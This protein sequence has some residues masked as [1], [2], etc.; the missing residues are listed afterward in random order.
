MKY[1]GIFITVTSFLLIHSVAMFW[2][3]HNSIFSFKLEASASMSANS[4]D[5]EQFDEL[6]REQLWEEQMINDLNEK[7]V[8]TKDRRKRYETFHV[9]NL[10][11][12]RAIQGK[13]ASSWADFTS[14]YKTRD[15]KKQTIPTTNE[16]LQKEIMPDKIMTPFDDFLVKEELR[17][18]KNNHK[19]EN[20]F[21]QSS[22]ILEKDNMTDEDI[23]SD[24]IEYLA[25]DVVSSEN[26]SNKNSRV[27]QENEIEIPQNYPEPIASSV[28]DSKQINNDPL[29]TNPKETENMSGD[30]SSDKEQT[31]NQLDEEEEASENTKMVLILTESRHGSTWLMDMLSYPDTSVPV[32][33]PLNTPFLKMY[34]RSDEIRKEALDNGH[35]PAIYGD[36]RSVILARICLC[37]FHGDKIEDL[38]LSGRRYGSIAGI[39]Y[40][41]KRFGME[42]KEVFYN[43]LRMCERNDSM[44]VPK[45]IRLYNISELSILPQLGCPNFKV[46]HLVRDPRAVFLSR[47]RVFHE[48]YDGNILLG[49]RFKGQE[50]FSEE[51]MRR[52]ARDLCSHHVH[53]YQVGINPPDWLKDRYKMVIYEDMATEPD[54]WARDLLNFIGT[55]YTDI[56]K[57]YVY[58]TTHIK[59]RGEKEKG[60]YSVERESKEIVN[61]WKK[62][63]IPSHWKTIEEEC[64]DLLE[65][66]GYELEFA[67]HGL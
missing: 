42:Y 32:F 45:T 2:L 21:K 59:E 22:S 34:A 18:T 61:F 4:H 43:S 26:Y 5:K 65:I 49:D 36:W 37:D 48:L 29:D 63:L 58:N 13:A 23:E 20:F 55:P 3:F 19:A 57:E 1:K 30:T 47:M 46:I 15:S 67:D 14:D 33:E 53:N 38:K 60:S 44:T 41:A 35:D 31:R 39:G 28:Q 51:Y 40:K 10:G 66:M 25:K 12:R 50:A 8:N 6:T 24:S 52:A 16:V 17:R 11:I 27:D 54:V 62:K 56:H 9:K 7:E 64:K